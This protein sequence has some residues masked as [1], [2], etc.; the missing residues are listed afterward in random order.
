MPYDIRTL[1]DRAAQKIREGH[2]AP[3]AINSAIKDVAASSEEKEMLR[4]DIAREL[5]KRSQA[6]KRK[7]KRKEKE[8]LEEEIKQTL[9]DARHAGHQRRDH[10]LLD[11]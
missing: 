6:R 1:A 10:L 8:R 4:S 2:N 9:R 7:K 5:N 11:P 3:H